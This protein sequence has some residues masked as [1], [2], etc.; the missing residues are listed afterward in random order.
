M[1]ELPD[2]ELPDIDPAD[3][4]IDTFRSSGAGG[5]H[6]NATIRQLVLLAC[7]PGLLLNVGRTFTT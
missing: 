5:Q 6:I 1:P 4:R 3:L 2:A 7:R